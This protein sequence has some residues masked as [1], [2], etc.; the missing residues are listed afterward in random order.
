MYSTSA[1]TLVNTNKIS[2]S[3][4]TDIF[5]RTPPQTRLYS[6]APILPHL[7][8][9]CQ[10]PTMP[11][12]ITY[13]TE[14]Y[15]VVALFENEG[16]AR[17]WLSGTTSLQRLYQY[18]ER[19]DQPIERE[20]SALHHALW[21]DK[22]ITYQESWGSRMVIPDLHITAMHILTNKLTPRYRNSLAIHPYVRGSITGCIM[23]YL[24]RNTNEAN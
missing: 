20:L 9:P 17:R 8:H 19:D 14:D 3:Q 2:Q 22:F 18:H 6:T 12:F 1:T 13:T 10:W 21:I 5:H 16:F 7:I 11:L 4:P 24:R 23:T 15:N